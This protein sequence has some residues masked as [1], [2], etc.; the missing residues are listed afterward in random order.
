MKYSIGLASLVLAVASVVSAPA[1]AAVEVNEVGANAVSLCQGSLP[2]FETLLRK[3]PLA[4]QNEGSNNTF[5]TCS[6]STQYDADD[7][8]EIGYFGAFLNNI[9]TAPATVS[10]TGV[11]GFASQGAD[12]VYISKS[13]IV[14]PGGEGFI[15]FT[16][17]DNEGNGY[18]PLV[19]MNCHLP[20]GTGITDT[21]V[22]F[23]VDDAAA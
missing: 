10:C 21:A 4:V 2:V 16:T 8:F 7:I 17:V 12:T 1:Q 13:T 18:Y 20:P 19:N 9:G 23:D 22:G 15:F 3:R 11:A 14:P 5:V 6:F